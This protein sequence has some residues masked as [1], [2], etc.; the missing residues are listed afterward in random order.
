MIEGLSLTLYLVLMFNIPH[1]EDMYI[2]HTA[3]QITIGSTKLGKVIS[4]YIV[5]PIL[6]FLSLFAS[7]ILS[8]LYCN[9]FPFASFICM[10]P[11][12]IY[13]LSISEPVT[14]I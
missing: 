4:Q 12:F 6:Y 1:I 10:F 2:V 7:L 8:S 5:K 3:H 11:F 13:L 9:I 14:L